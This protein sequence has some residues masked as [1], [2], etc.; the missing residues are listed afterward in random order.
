[1]IIIQTIF[2]SFICFI[3]ILSVSGLGT[4]LNSAKKKKL[5]ES[6]F[7]GFLVI[8]L[9]VTIIHF[10]YKI[11]LIIIF[12]IFVV[13]LFA[14]IKNYKPLFKKINHDIYLYVLLP[15]HNYLQS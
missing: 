10:F 8:A 1:M 12:L 9:T 7:Y 13:G 3:T 5:L 11:N 14:S 4:L 2:F 15:L 6:F